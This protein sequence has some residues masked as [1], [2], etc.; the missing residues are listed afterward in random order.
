M[1]LQNP[2]T[3]SPS[4]LGLAGPIRLDFRLEHLP[5][6]QH[7]AG[8][9]GLVLLAR[10]LP[11]PDLLEIREVT[12]EGASFLIKRPGL[13]QLLEELYGAS[14]RPGQE[15]FE[16][17]AA[18]MASLESGA[19]EGGGMWTRLWLDW[20]W[21]IHRGAPK[22][23]AEGLAVRDAAV[24]WGELSQG[25]LAGGELDTGSLLGSFPLTLDQVPVRGSA[26]HRFLLHFWP[27]AIMVFL[28][29]R[30][31]SWGGKP[32]LEGFVAAIPDV[33]DL[34]AF[35][36]AYPVAMRH[37]SQERVG[38]RPREAVVD[39]PV[40]AALEFARRVEGRL[41]AGPKAL[42]YEAHHATAQGKAARVRALARVEPDAALLEA[43]GAFRSLGYADPTFRRTGLQNLLEGAP[44]YRG[45]QELFGSAGSLRRSIESEAFRRDVRMA[46]RVAVR[47]RPEGAGQHLEPLIREAMASFVGNQVL[48]KFKLPPRSASGEAM[49]G[50]DYQD[51]R[52]RVATATFRAVRER[53]GASFAAY[54]TTTLLP[55]AEPL[56]GALASTLQR[57]LA[58]DPGLLRTLTLLAL[59]AVA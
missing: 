25:G 29:R 28:L 27:C 30:Q 44:W 5:S 51:K 52:R 21:S 24:V 41:E 15:A 20:L 2:Q 34:K 38:P 14:S 18:F 36:D 31:R 17:R 23:R 9:A 1:T 12:A 7:R 49:P 37:R 58:Q 50:P 54:F 19:P 46:F 47:T 48:A 22:A 42:A 16:P 43:Y 35:C 57:C 53:S 55:G 26:S 3:P 32:D 33:H 59:T 4:G 11:Q 6:A 45:C 56:P 40:E 10:W 8:L 13:E 39:L